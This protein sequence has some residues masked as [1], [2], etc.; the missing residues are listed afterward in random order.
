[1]LLFYSSLCALLPRLSLPPQHHKRPHKKAICPLKGANRLNSL[2][3]GAEHLMRANVRMIPQLVSAGYVYESAPVAATAD[4]VF[5]QAR[6]I[7]CADSMPSSEFY[8]LAH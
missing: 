1:M 5:V 4:V 6:N 2:Q 7:S 8:Q 3:M